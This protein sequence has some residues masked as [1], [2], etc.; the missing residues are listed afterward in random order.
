MFGPSQDWVDEAMKVTPPRHYLPLDRTKRFKD[1]FQVGKFT[2]MCYTMLWGVRWG[3][4]GA[5][6]AGGPK[7]SRQSG[8]LNH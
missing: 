4:G 5:S 7:K 3:P 6:E 8:T 2:E 1:A